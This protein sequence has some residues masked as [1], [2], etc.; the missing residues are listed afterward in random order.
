MV[1][2]MVLTKNMYR[3][4]KVQV[5]TADRMHHKL[6]IC[7]I[8]TIYIHNNPTIVPKDAKRSC[9]QTKGMGGVQ[10]KGMGGWECKNFF[11]VNSSNSGFK[12]KSPSLRCSMLSLLWFEDVQDSINWDSALMSMVFFVETVSGL[13]IFKDLIKYFN[14]GWL[15][16]WNCKL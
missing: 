1:I 2:R 16:I 4:S 9:V 5:C 11:H 10:T 7:I 13:L 6:T 8:S 12:V 3:Y 15:K 14:C